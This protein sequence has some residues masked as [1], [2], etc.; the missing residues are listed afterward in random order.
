MPVQLSLCVIIATVF[1]TAVANPDINVVCER[2]SVKIT[3][4]IAPELV[5]YAARFFLGNC[6]ASTLNDLTT[7]EGELYFSYSF[8][9]CKFKRLIKGKNVHYQN[10]L[11]YRPYAKSKKPAA[12]MYPVNCTYK[13][14]EVWVPRY[15]NAGSGVSESRGELVFHMALLNERLTGV[16][17]TNLIPEGSFMAIWAAVEQKSHQPLLLLIEDCVAGYTAELQLNSQV[18]PIIHNKGCIAKEMG[19]N[20]GFLQRYHSSALTFSLRAFMPP[21][22]NQVYIHCNLIV[23]DPEGLA[24]DKKACNYIEETK[25]WELLDDPSQS[26]LCNCCQSTCKSRSKRGVTWD[27]QSFSHKSVLGPLIIVDPSEAPDSVQDIPA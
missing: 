10:Q 18:Y 4:K 14:A 24:E 6:M 7:G 22:G 26:S 17:K 20:A 3:W 27:P 12:Y 23:W 16:A 25:S 9:E 2:N 21:F 13:R 15:L 1:A 5:P 19:E 11:T 8:N